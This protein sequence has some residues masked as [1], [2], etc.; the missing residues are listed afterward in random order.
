[1]S[2][3]SS[4][5]WMRQTPIVV[6]EKGKKSTWHIC[7]GIFAFQFYLWRFSTTID[8]FENL[9]QRLKIL[10]FKQDSIDRTWMK[11]NIKICKLAVQ[12]PLEPVRPIGSS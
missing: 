8:T 11:S 3:V 4:S 12:I 6:T 2:M 9:P 10:N 5:V 7:H 1:M